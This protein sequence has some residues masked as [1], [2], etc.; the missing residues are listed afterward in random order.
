MLYSDLIRQE[1]EYTYS[2]NVQ[3][4]IENDKKLGRFIPNE[5]TIELFREYFI[6]I[7]RANPNHHSRI[8]YGSYGTGKSHFLTVLSL[9]L[10]KAFT[11]GVAFDTFLTRVN[12][13]D[14]NLAQ[15]INAFVKDET[16]KPFLI[17]P[18]VFDFED[19]D[20]CIYF[21]LTKKLSSIGISVR[22]KTF[23]T[24]A[25]EQLS[26]WKEDEESLN[27][28]KS[29]C[30][31]EKINLSDLEKSLTA[32]D[33]KAESVFNR[34]FNK[35]TFG[36]NFVCEVSNLTESLTQ[37]TEAISSQ[38]SGMVFIFDEFGRYIEDNIKKIKVRSVQDLAEY[39]QLSNKWKGVLYDFATKTNKTDI[40][41]YVENGKW[42][43]R[44]GASGLETRNVTIADTPCN[45]SDRAR[46]IVIKKKL[47]PD[48][49]EFFKPF[50]KLEIFNKED[51]TY[52]TITE[53]EIRNSKGDVVYKRK[54]VCDLVI[55][56]GTPVLKVLPEKSTDIQLI[57]SRLKCQLRKYQY[58]IRCSACDSI[59]PY[60][61]INTLG[62]RRYS[63]DES[64]CKQNMNECSKCI[65]KFYNGCITCQV[66]AGKKDVPDEEEEV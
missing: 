31:K 47:R 22:F 40:E 61:A 59:C 21:S 27:R 8:L 28:L 60:G 17:V 34:L 65:A 23:Y 42:K 9:L 32:F 46:N 26:R 38:Y 56:W 7:I 57:I 10:S 58:C 43:T 64:R 30:E 4:D 3:F 63:I 35:M 50:G 66:L 25:L 15:D 44:K 13:Y 52:I 45:L 55:T 36:V 37:V 6:D 5:T 29:T 18:I 11:D 54:K 41:D 33:S 2:A 16:R 48:V 62:D 1:T 14:P 12:E 53:C 20:R 24:Q 19:F 39:P 51:A 49:I